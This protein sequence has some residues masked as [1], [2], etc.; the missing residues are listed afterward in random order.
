MLADRSFAFVPRH[1][2]PGYNRW[3]STAERTK[4]MDHM[5]FSGNPLHRASNER[6]DEA[7]LEQ[8]SEVEGSL[9]L[10]FWRLSPLTY[11]SDAPRLLWLDATIRGRADGAPAPV[12]LGIR[13]SIAH[14]AIDVSSLDEPLT[15]LGAEGAEF[16]E[17]RGVALSL[18]REEAGIVAHA[19][20]LLD[21][22]QRN[23]FCAA[24]G[25]E[26]AP[27]RGGSMRKCDACSAEHFPRTD[28]VV[29]MV[30]Y[31][32]NECLL[33]RRAGRP[34]GN[35]SALAGFIE[36]GETIEEAVRREVFEEVGL[37]IDEVTYFASQPWPFPSS[38]MIGCFARAASDDVQLDDDEIAE[39]R[40]FS[41]A[42]ARDAVAGRNP[43]LT[44]AG[45]VAIA[46]HL[47]KAWSES[48]DQ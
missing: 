33:G 43:Q 30:V 36:Q 48:P 11:H 21:W 39:A 14:Y 16:S 45:P 23:R 13:D 40:W 32:G 29:I 46:Y 28:P 22:H 24:C 19:R 34:A 9:F 20:S 4:R 12:L 42:E 41:K 5:P 15:V 27:Q 44:L 31:R 2:Y 10:P 35:F 1:G 18:P 47:I 26:T 8:L 38:L 25:C 37:R 3:R 17:T 7:W 6:K